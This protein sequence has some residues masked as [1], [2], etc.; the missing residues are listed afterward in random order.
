MKRKIALS[1]FVILVVLASS[2]GATLAWFTDQSDPIENIFTA[3]TVNIEADETVS[4]DDALKMENWNPGDC[5][6]KVFTI[7]NDGSKRVV[8]RTD[9]SAVASG[10]WYTEYTDEENNTPWNPTPLEDG[11][12][13]V[14]VTATGDWSQVG[15]HYYY[16]GII[17]SG[18]SVELTLRVCLN[19]PK[20]TNDYQG[21]I[22]VMRNS[23]YAIQSSNEASNDAWGVYWDEDDEEW[24]EE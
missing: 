7:T 4:T 17:E 24:K 15:D 23:F 13:P 12:E 10:S 5:V 18:E 8:L 6:D 2:L 19:G 16:E 1:M 14:T 9:A 22:F 3:G 21:K 11:T 20:L